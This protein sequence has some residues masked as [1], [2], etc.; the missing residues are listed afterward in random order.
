MFNSSL[1]RCDVALISAEL[2]PQ[3]MD[4]GDDASEVKFI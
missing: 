4:E 3:E 1:S 2:C